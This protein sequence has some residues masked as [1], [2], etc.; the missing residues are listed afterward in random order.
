MR[1][2]E[3]NI[4]LESLQ[5]RQATTLFSPT[6]IKQNRHLAKVRRSRYSVM[7]LVAN[8]AITTDARLKYMPPDMQSEE[9]DAS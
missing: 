1:C 9:R 7:T 2:S 8:P 3:N 4:A 6:H 5:R